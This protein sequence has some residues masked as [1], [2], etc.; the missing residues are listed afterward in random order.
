MA[1]GPDFFKTLGVG[2]VRGREITAE[3][4]WAGRRVVVASE[5]LARTLWPGEDPL[6]QPLALLDDHGHPETTLEIVGVAP[7]LAYSA[8]NPVSRHAVYV[9]LPAAPDEGAD[10]LVL[11]QVIGDI[12]TVAP[13]VAALLD[14]TDHRARRSE[15][16]RPLGD[17][18]ETTHAE[19]VFLLDLL[20]VVGV[21]TLL[22]AAAGV[23][24]VT[25]EAV[26][27]NTRELGI[28]AALGAAPG[29]LVGLVLKGSLVKV[30]LGAA[31]GL[32]GP[33]LYNFSNPPTGVAPSAVLANPRAWALIGAA[34]LLMV[35]AS[36]LAARG[37]ARADPATAMRAE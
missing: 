15:G 6:G 11:V 18:T 12:G 16:L 20:G 31:L 34:V 21:L 30:G 27:L 14:S 23:V 1:V 17:L 9:P 19:G 3:D 35:F 28:R 13:A 25:V 2:L 26:W 24:A 22:L 36:Y 5:T 4:C 32:P 33:L 8:L 37:A 10:L 29:D 7:D